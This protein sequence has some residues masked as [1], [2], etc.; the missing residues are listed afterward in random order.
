MKTFIE[1]VRDFDGSYYANMLQDGKRVEGLPENVDYKTLREGIKQIAHF[2]ILPCNQMLF[3]Q[4]GRKSYAYID[5]TQERKD[6]R[7]TM[8]EINAGYKSS[9]DNGYGN[10]YGN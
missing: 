9:F 1:V 6:C 3:S 10:Y 2:E 5:A 8:R 4:F 7:V